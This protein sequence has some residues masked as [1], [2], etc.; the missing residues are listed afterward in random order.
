MIARE[1]RRPTLTGLPLVNEELSAN[2]LPH[3]SRACGR[4]GGCPGADLALFRNWRHVLLA[5]A[6]TAIGLVWAGGIVA[7]TRVELDLF[8]LFAVM[9]FVGIGVDYGVHLIHRYRDA[10]IPSKY[11]RTGSRYSGGR[12]NHAPR[13]WHVDDLFLSSAS[14]DRARVRGERSDFVSVCARVARFAPGQK[15]MSLDV[16]ALVPALNESTTIGAVVAG[17]GAHVRAVLVVDDGSTDAT[18]AIAARR[19]PA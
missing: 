18:A 11:G 12:R 2:F 7:L 3:S 19:V 6:P 9:T 5:L 14:V 13:I 17:V 1:R 4:F 15:G 10:A 8:A 16:V